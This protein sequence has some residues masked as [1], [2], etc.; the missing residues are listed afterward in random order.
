MTTTN[1]SN[2]Q[3][4]TSMIYCISMFSES[5]CIQIMLR[6][7]SKDKEKRSSQVIYVALYTLQIH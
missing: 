1:T 2:K 6:I 5:K 3:T 7:S 4:H